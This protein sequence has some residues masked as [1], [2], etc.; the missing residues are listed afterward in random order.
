MDELI[1]VLIIQSTLLLSYTAHR[2]RTL[3]A[4]PLHPSTIDRIPIYLSIVRFATIT[5]EHNITNV[6]NA[7]LL[8]DESSWHQ[9]FFFDRLVGEFLHSYMRLSVI[10]LV[11]DNDTAN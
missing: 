9:V 10:D 1:G 7:T 11:K 8:T 5:L 3:Y 4:T 2:K 6:Y